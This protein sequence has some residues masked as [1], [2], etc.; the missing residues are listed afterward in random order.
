MT[1]FN[2]KTTE[3]LDTFIEKGGDINQQNI[4]GQTLL[5]KFVLGGNEIMIDHVLKQENVN[6]NI[7]DIEGK[8]PIY[9]VKDVETAKKLM[10]NRAYLFPDACK[11]NECC[12]NIHMLLRKIP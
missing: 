8:S 9:Y 6:T 2:I 12:L 1:S 7:K 10:Q 3:Q 11:S 5:H 4:F